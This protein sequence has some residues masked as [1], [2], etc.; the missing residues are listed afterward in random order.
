M[1]YISK[2]NSD[3][4]SEK[5]E[6]P[7]EFPNSSENHTNNN[8]D[9]IKESVNLKYLP[10]VKDEDVTNYLNKDLNFSFKD[11]FDSGINQKKIITGTAIQ[12]K[13][14][15]HL[16]N[17]QMHMYNSLGYALD[18]SDNKSNSYVINKN[19]S[20]LMKEIEQDNVNEIQT[21]SNLDRNFFLTASRTKKDYAREL[22]SKRLKY[23]DP[24]TGEFKGPWAGYKGDE[25]F[26]NVGD[27]SEEQKEIL[28]KLEVQRKE[29]LVDSQN[30]V[31]VKQK[32]RNNIFLITFLDSTN[33]NLSSK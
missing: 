1:E 12:H 29:K 4:D 32:V 28:S 27:L 14:N 31:E 21:V 3:S 19:K 22:K 9:L 5:S 25:I 11:S 10:K 18:P 6:K 33:I 24:S 26:S 16:F 15:P 2:Y 30:I 20:S 7:T 8:D 17:E 23:G 13:I